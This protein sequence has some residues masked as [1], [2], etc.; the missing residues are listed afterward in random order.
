MGSDPNGRAGSS[1]RLGL[2][3]CRS[4]RRS[5]GVCGTPG[6]RAQA[7]RSCAQMTA[8]HLGPRHLFRFQA[9]FC[10]F[11]APPI[12]CASLWVTRGSSEGLTA[13]GFVLRSD[14]GGQSWTTGSLP[15][16][17]GFAPTPLSSVSCAEASDCMAIGDTSIPNPERCQGRPPMAF[18]H[19]ATTLADTS[20][21]DLISAVVTSSDGG[22]TWQSRP[23][24]ADIPIP[25]LFS[26][27]C[28]SATV[29]WA[30]GQEAVPQVIGN[31][32][33][34]GSPV[35]VG[36]TDGGAT[37]SKAT[38]AIPSD[39]PNYLGQAYLAIGDISCPA[40]SACLALGGGG[41]ERSF[42]AHLS[43]RER[44]P[45][46]TFPSLV[47]ASPA[48]SPEIAARAAEMA[49]WGSDLPLRRRRWRLGRSTSTTR[50]RSARRCRV[51]PAP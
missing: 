6:H 8:G 14:D 7:L 12:K 15:Q 49:S 19:Q 48:A 37:W 40:T 4:M 11:R 21:N 32:H 10:R 20:P 9:R 35:M 38:F 42:Y 41:P 17:F 47:L 30:S 43:V 23:L 50:I 29:C 2:P 36:T 1:S 45:L 26:L 13:S 44:C 5:P 28:A 18:R 3:L 51:S 22:A 46:K 27:S 16:N 33:D 39:A 34:E 25:Q 24:P 31:V